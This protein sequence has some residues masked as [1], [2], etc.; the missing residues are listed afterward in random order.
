MR[1]PT[2]KRIRSKISK[3]FTSSKL[4]DAFYHI[5]DIAEQLCD[6]IENKLKNFKADIPLKAMTS[7]YTI[8]VTANV[9]FGFNPRSLQGNIDE[10]HEAL[11]SIMEVTFRRFLDF[12]GVFMMILPCLK[13]ST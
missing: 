10:L 11:Y 9:L 8:D 5:D 3:I 4:K 12:A 6:H 7:L 13:F 1:N 2:W